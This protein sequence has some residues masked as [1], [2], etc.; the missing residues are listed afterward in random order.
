MKTILTLL[1]TLFYFFGNS[2]SFGE[3]FNYSTNSPK[4]S[5]IDYNITNDTLRITFEYFTY[6][7]GS[8]YITCAVFGCRDDHRTYVRERFY[9]Y[10]KSGEERFLFKEMGSEETVEK[11][12][13][14]KEWVFE[15]Q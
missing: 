7:L 2:Q 12:T 6:D 13:T 10:I 15:K 5:I 4:H 14:T 1:L 11:T 9:F 3:L 8:P